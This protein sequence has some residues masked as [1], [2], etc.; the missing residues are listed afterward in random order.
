M[1][2]DAGATER[3][4]WETVPAG[5]LISLTFVKVD[6]VAATREWNELPPDQ[7]ERRYARYTASVEGVARKMAAAWPLHWRS[8]LQR[9]RRLRLIFL[10]GRCE[11]S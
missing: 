9:V 7:V 1:I 5:R 8:A 3:S 11:C 6:R 4:W 10:P 2:E